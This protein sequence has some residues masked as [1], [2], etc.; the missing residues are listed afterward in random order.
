MA[1]RLS[2]CPHCGFDLEG[3]DDGRAGWWKFRVRLYDMSRAD[4]EPMADSD[5]EKDA[6][7]PG[8]EVARGLWKVMLETARAAVTWHQGE[9]LRGMGNSDLERKIRGI[10]ATLSRRK[11]QATI[12]MEYDTL[13]SFSDATDHTPR[14]LARVDVVKTAEP[15]GKSVETENV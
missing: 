14:Y 7:Q 13:D 4:D 15:D 3:A 1:T 12:R 11:G 5:S 9:V 2:T 10:R 6:D 8:G